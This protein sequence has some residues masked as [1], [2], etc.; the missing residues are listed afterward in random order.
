MKIV[1]DARLLKE[2]P[3]DGISRFTHEVVTRIVSENPDHT[4]LLIGE[5]KDHE[6]A[7]RNL[8]CEW[9][10]LNPP[11]RHPVQWYFRNEWQ[12]P[13]ILKNFEADV[14]FSPD[15]MMPL[16]TDAPCLPV[17]HDIN[18]H[19]RPE[20]VPFAE[21]Y[22]YN[23]FFRKFAEKATR[24]ITVSEFCKNDISVH[25]GISP[26]KI[27]VAWNG[28]SDYFTPVEER[29][30]NEFIYKLTGGIPYFLFVS[31][32]SPRKNIPGLIRAYNIFRETTDLKHK[33]VLIGGRLFLN[34]ETDRSIKESKWRED[35]ILPG[36]VL[37]KDLH[38]YYA[39][40]L[41]L[42]FVPWF[43]GFGIPA[44]EAMRC[45]TPVILSNTS[46]L[47]EVGGNAALYASPG[48][49]LEIAEAMKSIANDDELRTRLSI[50]GRK[51]SLNF[52]WE[53]T[54]KCVWEAIRKT[55]PE[56]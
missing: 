17:I 45:G 54:A 10:Y 55:I 31:N 24:I 25:F 11:A 13:P 8:S 5:K 27:D 21:R 53:N 15:G 29:T 1:I 34:S 12:I 37:H 38:I 56:R 42:V 43:E 35:I 19:H 14:Y 47:P 51:Q 6:K 30:R 46:S 49:Q 50:A 9:I 22:Y 32:F 20:D 40:A 41:A 36:S 16:S 23:R 4:F 44:A 52:T 2:V 3:D 48:N 7:V 33:L 28:V 39:S 18:F 26:E